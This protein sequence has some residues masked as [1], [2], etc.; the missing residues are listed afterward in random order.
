MPRAYEWA[1]GSRE[2]CAMSLGSKRAEAT[3]VPTDDPRKNR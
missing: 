1:T 3:P 2:L